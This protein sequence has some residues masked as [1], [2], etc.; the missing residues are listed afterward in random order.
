[1]DLPE[2]ISLT[3]DPVQR[4]KLQRKR[5][6]YQARIE[7][8][9]PHVNYDALVKERV[10]AELLDQGSV[11]VADLRSRLPVPCPD[12]DRLYANA[13]AVVAAYNADETVALTGG[14]RLT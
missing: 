13:V 8:K 2:K 4:A 10:L 5:E 3:D 11:D 14:T 12:F 7:A 6:E 1:M 9:L